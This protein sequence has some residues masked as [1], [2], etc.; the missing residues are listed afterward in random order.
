MLRACNADYVAVAPCA[1][2]ALCVCARGSGR[3][4]LVALHLTLRAICAHVCTLRFSVVFCAAAASAAVA[5]QVT[6]VEKA[7]ARDGGVAAER[8]QEV[9]EKV[10]VAGR[11]GREGGWKRAEKQ[12]ESGRTRGIQLPRLSMPTMPLP[13]YKRC[14]ILQDLA[15][16]RVQSKARERAAMV[17]SLADANIEVR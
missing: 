15:A 8:L 16:S 17:A 3:S 10:R 4:I 5:V 11:E 1:L 2:L 12:K 13:C 7:A 6:G 9:E 14:S